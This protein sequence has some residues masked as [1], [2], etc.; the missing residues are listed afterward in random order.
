MAVRTAFIQV[1]LSTL[2]T[3][4]PEVGRCISKFALFQAERQN[5]GVMR[6]DKYFSQGNDGLAEM[7]PIRNDLVA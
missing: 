2:V 5:M 3:T 6:D 1:S 4:E 7:H